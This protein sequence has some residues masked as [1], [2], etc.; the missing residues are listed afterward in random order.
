MSLG[1]ARM[2]GMFSNIPETNASQSHEG[3][4]VIKQ[5]LNQLLIR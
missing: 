3:S 2:R 1:Q 5:M 4:S